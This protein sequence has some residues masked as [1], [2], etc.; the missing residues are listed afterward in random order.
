MTAYKTSDNFLQISANFEYFS[1]NKQ[2]TRGDNNET[3]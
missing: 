3:K 1:I 2:Y